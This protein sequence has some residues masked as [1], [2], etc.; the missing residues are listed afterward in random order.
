MTKL[1]LALLAAV[2]AAALAGCGE[3]KETLGDTT[4]VHGPGITATPPPWKPEY[5]HLKQR[6]AQLK[7]PPVGKEQV[8][9]HALLH[10]YNDGRLVEL[11]PNIGID[12]ARGVYSSIHTHDNTGIVH[13]ESERPFNFT[14]G[15]FFA[16]WGVRFGNKS[17]GS[18]ENDGDNRVHVYV[19]GKPIANPVHYVLRDQDNVVIG[20]GTAD[21][22]PHNPDPRLL[23][24]VS[25]KGGGTCSKNPKGKGGGKSCVAPGPGGSSGG[26][27]GS[28]G[29]GSSTTP[30]TTI[31]GG[32]G[33]GQ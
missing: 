24:T 7:L 26:S 31:P 19:N 3:K 12:R 13:M 11:V 17:L 18:L 29:G 4:A 32:S 14:L 21:S 6:I 33:N 20:Y 15:T 8:H 2:A 23:K 10:I 28:G 27:G 1:L 16:V 9:H 5:A 22:F 25:G 30:G